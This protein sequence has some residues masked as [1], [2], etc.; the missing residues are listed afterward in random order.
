MSG[1]AAAGGSPLFSVVMPAYNAS[2]TVAEAVAS[3]LG[4]TFAN[5]ELVVVDDGSTDG[6]AGVVRACAR[7]DARVRVVSQPNMGCGPARGVA[8]EHARGE[9]ACR[10]DADD[11]YTPSYLAETAAFIA[12]HPGYDIYACNGW[13]LL[14]D[15][16]RRPYHE[17]PRAGEVFSL[18]LEDL[19]RENGIFTT[20]VFRRAVFAPAGGMRPDIY[21]EDYDFW[22]RAM[23][24]GARHIYNPRLL[25]VCRESATQMT[26]DVVRMHECEIRVLRD[27]LW[28]GRLTA[29][30]RDVALHSVALLRQNVR[31]RRLVLR[32]LGPARADRVFAL[33]HRLAWVIRPYRLRG[34]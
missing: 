21:C 28:S 31:V 2:A 19:L 24:A 30:E 29:R 9:Y 4:Q 26:A 27:V 5:W 17:G 14:P 11:I 3:V 15:G 16:S 23:L 22:L 18:A 33:A 12:A 6:T 7:G 25:S 13:R 20:A 1:P 32:L 34:H 10:L 8:V